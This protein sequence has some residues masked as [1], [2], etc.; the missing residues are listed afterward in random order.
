MVPIHSDWKQG[1]KLSHSDVSSQ[2]DSD[3]STDIS[4]T[5]EQP[6]LSRQASQASASSLGN[7]FSSSAGEFVPSQ[8]T[9][10]PAFVPTANAFRPA[11]PVQYANAGHIPAYLPN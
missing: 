5:Q 3:D 4:T 2:G 6:T 10:T 1:S 11:Q 9:S 8:P 7:P